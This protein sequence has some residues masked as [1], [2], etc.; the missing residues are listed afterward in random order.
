MELNFDRLNR[1]ALAGSSGEATAEKP[2]V[3]PAEPQLGRVDT[4]PAS[5]EAPPADGIEA[6]ER[7]KKGFGA[8]QWE[9]DQRK[10]E[11]YRRIEEYRYYQDNIRKSEQI[12]I[13]IL[14]GARAG[15]D[16]YTLFLKAVEAISC[17]TSDQLFLTQIKE[18]M[19]IIYGRGLQEKT[20][21]E[22]ELAETQERLEK[23]REAYK[24]EAGTDTPQR[25]AKAVEAHE[26]TVAELTRLINTAEERPA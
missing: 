11:E 22:L 9:A 1:L 14:K 24:R 16:I 18:D 2:S 3:T 12:Q 26:A 21:L 17:M 6:V 20:P 10:N 23:L 4:T 15:E 25:I 5:G 8:F 13:E 19:K 7:S